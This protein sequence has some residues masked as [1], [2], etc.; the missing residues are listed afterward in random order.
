MPHAVKSSMPQ[1]DKQLRLVAWHPQSPDTTKPSLRLL[2][3]PC[4]FTD[5]PE[6]LPKTSAGWRSRDGDDEALLLQ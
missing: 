4:S 6:F 2:R 1:S 5:M 3:L